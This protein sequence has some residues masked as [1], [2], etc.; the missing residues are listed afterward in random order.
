MKRLVKRWSLLWAA[1]FVAKWEGFLRV[2]TWDTIASPPVLTVGHGHTKYAGPPIPFEGMTVNHAQAQKILAHD[3][4]GAARAV[5]EHVDVKLTARQRIAIIS[6]V[7][8]LG[9]GLLVDTDFIRL[10]NAGKTRAAADELLK[11]NHAGGVVVEGLTNRRRAER[12]L[13]LHPRAP[14]RN[15]HRPRVHESRAARLQRERSHV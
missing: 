7:F 4:R 6:A 11:W 8:N 5:A 15:P 12:W 13:L 1:R 2:A 9:S 10:L 14:R 3:L